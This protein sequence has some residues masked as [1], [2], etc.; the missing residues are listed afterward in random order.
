MAFGRRKD[1]RGPELATALEEL[2]E[3][4]ARELADPERRVELWR[5]VAGPA[6]GWLWRGAVRAWRRGE[7]D[8]LGELFDLPHG[9]TDI[10]ACIRT[11]AVL[12]WVRGRLLPEALGQLVG[13]P[14]FGTLAAMTSEA[15]GELTLSASSVARA[16]RLIGRFVKPLLA[17]GVGLGDMTG[18]FLAHLGQVTFAYRR[19]LLIG[20]GP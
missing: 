14:A 1:E 16:L 8:T 7:L 15:T 18:R 19:D 3:A 10:G 2:R 20:L 12:P 17:L 13:T 9:A 4:A 11:D 5:T 6:A